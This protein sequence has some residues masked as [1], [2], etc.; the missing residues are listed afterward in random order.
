M[1]YRHYV[2]WSPD[3]ASCVLLIDLRLCPY[4]YGHACRISLPRHVLVIYRYC[5]DTNIREATWTKRE[6]SS[7]CPE[8][9][10]HE[11]VFPELFYVDSEN[12]SRPIFLSPTSTFR[13]AGRVVCPSA[14]EC[15][16]RTLSNPSP[17]LSLPTSITLSGRLRLNFGFWLFWSFSQPYESSGGRLVKLAG[18]SS[19]SSSRPASSR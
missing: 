10:D 5:L 16:G 17:S 18:R 9:D 14:G 11:D 7:I 1:V 3:T 4:E 13:L 19:S 12:Y 8:E 15:D 2:S 6:M